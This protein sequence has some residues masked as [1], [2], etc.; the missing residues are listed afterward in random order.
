MSE[1]TMSHAEAVELIDLLDDAKN[2]F[3]AYSLGYPMGHQQADAM[4]RRIE[5]W[6][7]P[8]PVRALT[9]SGSSTVGCGLTAA[10]PKEAA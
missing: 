10:L 8:R 6:N 7:R 2:A 3:H 4:R 5:R 9:D 1:V